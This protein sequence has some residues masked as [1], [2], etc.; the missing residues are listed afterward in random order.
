ML[1]RPLYERL[2][3]GALKA[4]GL[5]Q[6][7][8]KQ[9]L[10]KTDFF[11]GLPQ[12][13]M[14]KRT[15]CAEILA[16]CEGLLSQ[17]SPTPAD[18]WLSECYQELAHR[19]FPDPERKPLPRGARQAI[20]F[21]LTVLEWFLQTEHE[22]LPYDPLTDIPVLTELEIG[23]SLI[24]GEYQRFCE[25]IGQAHLVALMRLGREIMP[26]D[27]ASHTIGV[28]HM[29][30]HMARQAARAGLPVDI[31]M[32]S[33]AALSHDIGKFGCRG[34]D[35][36]RIPY[37]HYYYTYQ[38]LE[39]QGLPKIAHIA[40][41]H[42]TWDLEFENLSLESLLLIYAD[43]RV[44]GT[45]EN[46]RETVRIYTLAESYDLILSKLA[47][48]TPE[49]TRRY[50]T[51]YTKLSDFEQM[52]LGRGVQTE[53]LRDQM[54]PKERAHAAL[55]SEPEVL[56]AFSDQ[57][58]EN[59]IRLMYAISK[60]VTF[61]Q[62]L[63]RA[64]GEKNL[65]RIRTYLRL[66]GEYSTYM[67]GQNKRRTLALLYELLM[68]HQGDVRRQSAKIMGQ[69]LA[70]SGPKYRKELPSG[71]PQTAVAPATAAFLSESVE[72]WEQYMDRCLYPDHKITA[73][74]AQRISN[75]LKIIA[76]SL[77]KSCDEHEILHYLTPM[78]DRIPTAEG[79]AL[80]SLI[81]ALYYVPLQKLG[82]E[83]LMQLLSSFLRLLSQADEPLQVVIL[84]RLE[85][86]EPLL[87]EHGREL[88][89]DCLH[90]IPETGSHAVRY[91]EN[92]LR[93][94]LGEPEQP[95]LLPV[96]QLYLSNLKNAV[97]WMI[98]LTQVDALCDDVENRPHH[99]FHTATHLSN[100]LSVSEHLPV[101]ERAGRG[102]LAIFDRLTLEEQNE[103]IVDLMRELETGQD[104]I[105]AYIPQYLG[106]MLAK[107][108]EKEYA[109]CLSFLTEHIRTSSVRAAT[110]SL[111][112]ISKLIE[113]LPSVQTARIER[114]LGLLLTGV[115]HYDDTIHEMALTVLCE[116][117]LSNPSL[118]AQKRA[119]IF[120]LIGKKLLTLLSEPRAGQ[121][122]F[123]TKA[124][125][126]NRLYRFLV[127]CRVD[128]LRFALSQ[129]KPVA[130]F[131]GTFDP[132]TAGHRRIVEEILKLGFEVYLAID[133]F[134]WSKLPIPKLLRRQIAGMSVS[135][136][137]DVYIFPDELPINIAYP[138]ELR[139][140]SS[141]FAGRELYL[142]TGSDV[143]ANASAY[144]NDAPGGAATYNHIVFLRESGT[145]ESAVLEKLRGKCTLLTLP[146]FYENVSSTRIREYV[147]KNMDISMLVDPMVQSFIY[148][149]KLYLRAPLFKQN[150]QAQTVSLFSENQG[151]H[152][153]AGVFRRKDGAQLGCAYG[154]TVRAS[155][156]YSVLGSVEAAEFLRRHTSGRILLIERTEL[157]DKNK[158][159]GETLRVVLTELLAR[160]LTGDHTYAVCVCENDGLLRDTLSQLGFLPTPGHERILSV[161]MR[162][163][164]ILV[165]DVLRRLKEPLRSHPSVQDVVIKTR[166]LL[167]STLTK[168]FPGRLLLSFDS[169][170]L[171]SAVMDRVRKANGVLH[172]DP[173]EKTLGPGMCVPYGNVL[174]GEMVPNTVTK[175]LH[176]DK[177]YDNDIYHFHI[178]AFPGY[179]EP[180]G[181]VRTIRAFHRPVI[182]VD[183]LLHKGYRLE[184]L[185]AIFRKEQLEI[186]RIV[187]G[188]LTGRGKD[189]M[190][191]ER[192]N[193]DCEYFI[194]NLYYWFNESLL[195]PFIGGDSLGGT[196][197]ED[198]LL[199]T[200]N[201]I[202][203]YGYPDY[204]R[205]VDESELWSL[206]DTALHNA[207]MI[208]RRL[209]KCHQEEFATTLTI[210]R[211]AEVF[212]QPRAPYRGKH[213]RYDPSAMPSSYI[214]DDIE[215][216]LR[217]RRSGR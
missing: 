38:W 39:Q 208:L 59:N 181:Q 36:K 132:F 200:V 29:A 77:L 142:V 137:M 48:V 43:F 58:F 78:L 83:R 185:D 117:V 89:R 161:D 81:D 100:L 190:E 28:H 112:T 194:P 53:P 214:A 13:P 131:P 6:R 63:E 17:L 5:S 73:K 61:A 74:H 20:A 121:F 55:L 101:R 19:L 174:S 158:N 196:E 139:Q 178:C 138:E 160:S 167:R 54:Q 7:A 103:I 133:E 152:A 207:Y 56:H 110:A 124:A 84:R 49:K 130:F 47:D 120:V 118:D 4:E 141:L 193:V 60:D 75:S 201:L 171:D 163:P 86:L 72:L 57:M 98:K 153:K 182:L 176:V 165:Q 66:F 106:G 170:L 213:L 35:A 168:L 149:R 183:D 18:G 65:H 127:E 87:S 2:T 116:N 151:E 136:L 94:C 143:I 44:R 46:G 145:G 206:S 122:T 23:A 10:K 92:R 189:L 126:L 96:A 3:T 22:R 162:M 76:A 123:F 172:E 45:R 16:W 125:M 177:A 180:A 67:T 30:L 210:G 212:L 91:L 192:R 31:P 188:I 134:S 8:V 198:G 69:I 25:A 26:F 215:S 85:M 166:P 113:C 109:E 42:S 154:R 41:N 195:Y 156:L 50:R 197:V 51:A 159:D 144:R 135:D 140:L 128:G 179:S 12:Q 64:R 211:M 108:P 129:S 1:Y 62:L 9:L 155:E 90:S 203:P 216:F 209:E 150:I 204:L 147:D 115:G 88:C 199:P 93:R 27:P 175:S 99:A 34:S 79:E 217:I 102:L 68:H 15:N 80:F 187:V 191:C 119:G 33:A 111:L 184:K 40:A 14:Q 186:D 11:A 52:L 114:L 70:N 32:V 148:E 97:H 202:L 71:A 95:Q 173:S 82:E 37:L 146:E 157:Y 24:G 21:Y 104:E 205:G 169:E 164:V 107:L 105:S